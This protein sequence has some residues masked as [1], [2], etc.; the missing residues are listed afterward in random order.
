MAYIGSKG[1]YVQQL[2]NMGVTRHPTEKKKLEL[3]KTHVIRSLYLEVKK[4]RNE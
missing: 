2:K 1:W 3:F 4:S